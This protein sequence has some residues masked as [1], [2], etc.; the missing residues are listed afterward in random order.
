[1]RTQVLTAIGAME[2]RVLEPMKELLKDRHFRFRTVRS[3]TKRVASLQDKI[4]NSRDDSER[5]LDKLGRELVGGA[6]LLCFAS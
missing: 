1:M 3:A 2:E 6:R 5:F 4:L